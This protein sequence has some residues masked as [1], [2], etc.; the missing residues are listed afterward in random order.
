MYCTGKCSYVESFCTVSHVFQKTPLCWLRER[1]QYSFSYFFVS[2]YN[3]DLLYF[4]DI[5]I[6]IN[7]LASYYNICDNYG[8]LGQDLGKLPTNNFLLKKKS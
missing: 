5:L 1:F 2:F 6:K 8:N 4:G 3:R 7:I